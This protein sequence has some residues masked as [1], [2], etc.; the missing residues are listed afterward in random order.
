MSIPQLYN[1][2][3]TQEKF[4][5]SLSLFLCILGS[6]LLAATGQAAPSVSAHLDRQQFARDDAAL[7]TITIE[8][9]R[10]AD[11]SLPEVTGLTLS[12]RGKSSQFQMINGSFTAS[13]TARFL[14]QAASSGDY[15]IPAI[16]ITTGK[17]TLS[18]EP[19][20]FRVTPSAT[21][22]QPPASS[23]T[24]P[25]SA[26]RESDIAFLRLSPMKT[27]IYPGEIVPVEI[28]AYFTQR[29][30]TQLNSL[31]Q[32]N[33]DAFVLSQLD[34]KPRQSEEYI[35]NIPYNVLT[36]NSTLMA[37]K[38]G[39]SPLQMTLGATLLI[40]ERNSFGSMFGGRSGFNDELF[41]DFFGR[42]RSKNIKVTS[43]S[44]TITVLE[45]PQQGQPADFSGA[46][47]Q[48]DLQVSAT[49]T[50]VELGEPITMTTT[51]TGSGNFDRLEAP[52]FATGNG[53]KSYSPSATFQ[54]NDSTSTGTKVFEQAVVAKDATLSHIPPLSIN[55][56]DPVT[57]QY[58]EK[59]SAPI[60]LTIHVTNAEPAPQTSAPAA[61]QPSTHAVPPAQQVS[62]LA[63]IK[64]TMGKLHSSIQPLFTQSWFLLV[65]ALCLLLLLARLGYHLS[66]RYLARNPQLVQ[67]RRFKAQL[68]SSLQKV[69]EAQE[70][71]SSHAFMAA[72]RRAIQEQL[73]LLWQMEPY[74][75][76][77]ADLQ[78]RL[79]PSSELITLFA[80]AEQSAYS[81]QTLTALEMQDYADKLR[82]ELSTL[83]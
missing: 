77:L 27:E 19:I 48:F 10:S 20:S 32:L 63:P 60:P 21:A 80:A 15:S 22:V 46:I 14:V 2:P 16:A 69:S 7:L 55:Y 81:G 12:R 23:T 53:W 40:P 41:D 25:P 11:I 50:S 66:R 52:V 6:L 26:G 34:K 4:I 56:F 35:N 3:N 39:S 5:F 83:P 51:V 33:G 58:V 79:T 67:S 45:L 42:Y 43:P 17:D 78:G 44:T 18:T 28:K 64:S 65:V 82:H 13:I 1:C 74:A 47:G 49:P 37:I 61:V 68:T 30:K 8:G 76:T 71:G 9:V 57:K 38:E 59:K 31:P 54:G 29:I 73:G 72:C 24:T 62:G 75:I 70:H 36:W